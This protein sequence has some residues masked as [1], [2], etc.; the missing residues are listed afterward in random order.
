MI[1]VFGF[2][3]VC[4]FIFLFV[5]RAWVRSPGSLMHD[6]SNAEKTNKHVP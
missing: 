3:V 2:L 1:S 5:S 4:Q 6:Q